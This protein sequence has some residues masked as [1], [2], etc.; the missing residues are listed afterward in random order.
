MCFLNLMEDLEGCVRL[1][2]HDLHIGTVIG[3]V[4]Q[5]LPAPPWAGD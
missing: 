4:T 3:N 5:A 2:G 1:L